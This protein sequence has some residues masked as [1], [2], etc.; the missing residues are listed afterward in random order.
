MPDPLASLRAALSAESAASSDF[1]LNPDVVLPQGR[2]LR[3]A[4]VLVPIEIRDGV[5]HVIL[6]KRASHLKH[7]PGQIAFPGGKQD[8]ADADVIAAAL[9]EAREEI[10]LPPEIVDVIGTLP[11]HETVTSFRVTPVL[12][13]VNDVF[14][15]VPEPGEVEEVFRV[16]LAHVTDTARFSVQSRRW[17]GQRRH[18]FTVP[19]GPYYIWGATARILR[20]LAERMDQV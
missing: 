13:Q 19:F 11:T 17:Q 14:D 9:R 10:G 6:T 5:P 20:G 1:D 16:P 4:G 7:H 12:G 8:E 3:P 2:K 18:Y 15:I